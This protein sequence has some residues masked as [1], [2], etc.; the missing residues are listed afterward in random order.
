MKKIYVVTS[1]D[2]SDYHIVGVFATL[3]E[4]KKMI[5]DLDYEDDWIVA[6]DCRIEVRTLG[7]VDE[8]IDM[9]FHG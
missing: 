2:Y 1:G 3:G 4:A 7:V 9:N 6:G 5:D 8:E